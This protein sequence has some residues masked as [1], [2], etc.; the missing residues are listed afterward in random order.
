MHVVF[1]YNFQPRR[2]PRTEEL[3]QT[4]S[5]KRDPPGPVESSV[6]QPGHRAQQ[7]AQLTASWT[8]SALPAAPGPRRAKRR[9]EGV[10]QDDNDPDRRTTGCQQDI[11]LSPALIMLSPSLVVL[12]CDAQSRTGVLHLW[13]VDVEQL[14]RD[15]D[16][17]GL[18]TAM[19]L[20]EK[21]TRNV[22]GLWAQRGGRPGRRCSLQSAILFVVP[23][24]PG[25]W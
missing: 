24:N 25:T 9:E 15:K 6:L 10:V 2:K 19:M 20:G 8:S 18:I 1:F 16:G 4:R 21:F 5:Q 14:D 13:F 23:V 17:G 7:R 3:I 11:L 12:V 22:I